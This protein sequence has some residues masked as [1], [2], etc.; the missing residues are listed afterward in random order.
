[1]IIHSRLRIAHALYLT[2]MNSSTLLLYP[3]KKSHEQVVRRRSNIGFKIGSLN[4]AHCVGCSSLLTQPNVLIF[5][6][7]KD[8]WL[9][10]MVPQIQTCS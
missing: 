10:I 6:E 5:I 9:K 1:M 7:K 2:E 3:Q 4:L 8:L